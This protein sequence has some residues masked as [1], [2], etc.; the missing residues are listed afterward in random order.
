MMATPTRKVLATDSQA[1]DWSVAKFV[2]D[3][4]PEEDGTFGEEGRQSCR[5]FLQ[6]F[7]ERAG[8]FKM[9]LV[10]FRRVAMADVLTV[11][12]G[13]VLAEFDC[14]TSVQGSVLN[15]LGV[16]PDKALPRTH[17]LADAIT[18]TAGSLGA[19]HYAGE[20]VSCGAGLPACIILE[21]RGFSRYL[22][23][24]CQVDPVAMNAFWSEM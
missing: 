22:L 5:M 23:D 6:P 1:N 2:R 19:G 10:G 14:S 15:P 9:R 13:T 7:S 8:S 21:S 3:T 4:R 12:H 18:L 24:F 11:W 16:P 20:I 17:Y